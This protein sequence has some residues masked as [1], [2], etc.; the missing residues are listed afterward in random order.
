MQS[1]CCFHHLVEHLILYKNDIQ[2]FYIGPILFSYNKMI[3]SAEKYTVTI[4]LV[5]GV[6]NGKK[7]WCQVTKCKKIILCQMKVKK[8]NVEVRLWLWLAD[9]SAQ[10]SCIIG[11]F[12]RYIGLLQSTIV[13]Q[14]ANMFA[15]LIVHARHGWP[16][17]RPRD[18]QPLKDINVCLS[19]LGL[20]HKS[21]NWISWFS[22]LK[23][24][25]TL[26]LYW[27]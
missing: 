12:G 1:R 3:W 26:T 5:P 16:I 18:Y 10:K 7:I 20:M 23:I 24:V 25:Y 8:N 6:R 15:I 13:A 9:K 21:G 11:T 22:A 17:N 27:R 2:I 4:Y 14:L 19:I